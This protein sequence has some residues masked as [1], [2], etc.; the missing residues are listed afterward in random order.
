MKW[1]LRIFAFALVLSFGGEIIICQ[2]FEEFS[3]QV[4]E[5]YESFSNTTDSKF[6]AFKKQ[7]DQKFDK[8][9]AETDKEFSEYLGNNFVTYDLGYDKYEE[10]I[11]KPEIIPVVGETELNGNFISYEKSRSIAIYQGPVYPGIKKTEA[12][13]FETEKI[14]VEFL[15]WPLYFNID[16]RFLQTEVQNPSAQAIAAVWNEW[17]EL[18]YNSF[19]NQI[20]EVA[21]TLNLNQ[22]GYF[23]LLK[24]TSQ[25]V[26]PTSK[27]KQV[28]FQWAM[29]SRSRY[30]AKIGFSSSDL[31]LLIPSVYKMYNIDYVK[32]SG[33]NYYVIDGNGEQLQTYEKDFPET[34]ILMDVT[35]SKPFYTDP[36]KKS[37][38]FKFAYNKKDYSVKL[39]FDG[40]MIEFYKSIPLSDVSVYF[41]SAV[42]ERTKNSIRESFK[43][44]LKGRSD[45]DAAN[46]LLSFVQHAFDYKTDQ[47]VF[48]SE[49]YFFADELLHYPYADCEDRSVL[50]AYLVKTLL[51]KEVVA[52]SFPGHMA[53]AI[54]IGQE[55]DG[56]KV[57]YNN[58]IFVIADPT[59]LGARIGTLMPSVMEEKAELIA[60]VNKSFNSDMLT[61]AWKKTTMY[62]GFKAGNQRD[63]VFDNVGNIFVCGYF[64]G[65]ADFDG[66]KLKGIKGERDAFVV[67]Y[68][69]DL[70]M[71]WV[72]SANG[73]G[74][75]MAF[76]MAVSED[77]NLF[78]Y[79]SFENDLNFSGTE[80]EA[81]N[82]PDVFVA[83]YT[84]EGELEWVEKAGI[85]KLDHRLDF[86][87]AAK[88]NSEGEK[89]MAKLYTQVEDF[90]YYGIDL[91]KESNVLVK[92]SF[93]A[94]SG[95][96][97]NDFINYNF[98]GDL[99]DVPRVLYNT[100]KK[101][102]EKEYEET[103]AGLF[104]ALNLL[105]ANTV[106]IQG[107]NI[108]DAFDT[109][110]K[111][112]K[113]YASGFYDNLK[114]MKF[115]KNE[116][117]IV[118]IKTSDGEPIFLDKVKINNNAHIRI[119][120]YKSGNI[121]VE[122]LSGIYVGG[123][124]YWLD[125][126][127]IKLFKESGDLLFNFDTDNSVKKLN[128]KD[129]ILKH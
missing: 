15:G 114:D 39:D 2:T 75:D 40:Q 116:K 70:N 46:I 95:M 119:V 76:S 54:S 126:N 77:G 36:I 128:L 90:D 11:A 102:K 8:F 112:F 105:K 99:A 104:A 14:D 51:N 34:D 30:I 60:L 59:L 9:V 62:G 93:Y 97:S 42:S 27:N 83:K 113:D 80:I 129:E 16:N 33:I 125:M 79:G 127:S 35:I 106:E 87:F 26:Y 68:D 61:K 117:G 28:L 18:N 63:V 48:G 55:I 52:L 108:K 4:D 65:S 56:V 101:L 100:D 50:Y 17:G 122:V 1:F 25:K 6:A 94:T 96:S 29:L 44:I 45:V 74:N 47:Q 20:S 92:G 110:N 103:I 85:D 123:G 118:S 66:I 73:K 5:D 10:G 72:K 124:N 67:K 7:V 58:K 69:Q 86:M 22:W 38:V 64:N 81:I 53:V 121:L 82:A 91:D 88:F 21:N 120:K 111:S 115:L 12:N 41:N 84:I 23:Q 31:F 37:K 109:Y 19:L 32:V 57:E 49:R 24:K 13:N 107:S 3:K 71:V 89:I 98:E 78:V 43:P